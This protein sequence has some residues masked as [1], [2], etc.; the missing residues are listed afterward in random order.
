MT[1]REFCE[2]LAGAGITARIEDR[3]GTGLMA[4]PAG[5]LP[6]GRGWI[7]GGPAGE[8]EYFPAGPDAPIAGDVHLVVY[9]AL[10][11]QGATGQFTEPIAGFGPLSLADAAEMIRRTHAGGPG[12]PLS[13]GEAEA[14]LPAGDTV[15]AFTAC[16]T[17]LLGATW[18]RGEVLR[19]LRAGVLMAGGQAAALGHGLL[20]WPPGDVEPV[21]IQAGPL[22]EDVRRAGGGP[23]YDDQTV[24]YLRRV[25]R[26]SLVATAPWAT[27]CCPECGHD[28]AGEGFLPADDG[29][30][31]HVVI[32]GRLALGCEGYFII[33]PQAVGLP[34]DQWEDWRG[35]LD[36]AYINDGGP[37]LGYQVTLFGAYVGDPVPTYPE[38][39]ALLRA[40]LAAEITGRLAAGGWQPQVFYTAHATRLIVEFPWPLAEIKPDWDRPARAFD[41]AWW[42][43]LPPHTGVEALC[44]LCGEICNPAGPDDMIHGQTHAELRCGGPLVPVSYWGSK[45]AARPAARQADIPEACEDVN[46]GERTYP[47]CQECIAEDHGPGGERLTDRY[48]GHYRREHGNG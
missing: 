39:L 25:R 23:M 27:R 22:P 45:P 9:A 11:E 2:V 8:H 19:L 16:G 18:Q 5:I 31:A 43:A 32:R 1:P 44:L 46:T 33:D 14:M 28:V 7:L 13:F 41:Y 40:A 15:R 26:A 36:A 30:A 4:L 47:A 21:F 34:R 38:A 29:A 35:S 6:D 24:G 48:A 37:G 10:G 12:A 3:T 20:A 17:V 42:D